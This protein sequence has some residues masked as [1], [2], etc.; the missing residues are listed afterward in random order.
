MTSRVLLAR[1]ELRFSLS[2]CGAAPPSAAAASSSALR[3][4]SMGPSWPWRNV[5]AALS[6]T[7]APRT[8]E[9]SANQLGP[10]HCHRRPTTAPNPP[11]RPRPPR[12]PLPSPPASRR[13]KSTSHVSDHEYPGPHHPKHRY[14]PLADGPLLPHQHPAEHPAAAPAAAAAQ[15]ESPDHPAPDHHHAPHPPA[16]PHPHPMHDP[17]PELLVPAPPPP[18][19]L[20]PE[21]LPYLHTAAGAEA[22]GTSTAGSPMGVR[23]MSSTSTGGDRDRGD[24]G[25]D[26]GGGGSRSGA[27]AVLHSGS[28]SGALGEDARCGTHP[29]AGPGP[30]HG[31]AHA[32]YRADVDQDPDS[33]QVVS[34][35]VGESEGRRGGGGGGGHGGEAT[36]P[37]AS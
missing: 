32:F 34:R 33:P 14:G 2:P 19:D 15:G 20:S 36:P 1:G 4:G 22:A 30:V 18:R 13:P 27:A 28:G 31:S 23:A 26:T 7:T 10:L 24:E 29:A 17:D 35:P 9:R 21:L 6:V 11:P 25:A 12:R 5:A 16:H 8:L 3:C 37:L